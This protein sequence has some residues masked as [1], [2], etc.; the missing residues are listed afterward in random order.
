MP[1]EINRVVVDRLSDLLF[2]PSSDAADNLRQ[3]GYREDQIH[4]VGNVMID[5]LLANRARADQREVW[6]RFGVE[7]GGYGIVTLH[8]PANVDESLTLRGLVESIE[9]VCEQIPLI[10]PVHPRTR[11]MLSAVMNNDSRVKVCDPLGYLDFLSLILTVEHVKIEGIDL[12]NQP[13]NG[14]H[15]LCTRKGI[16]CFMHKP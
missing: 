3:E 5:T 14:L 6:K 4:L 11:P 2:A 8:R 9:S 1:E 10:F 13:D 12:L 7:R 16:R 15:L